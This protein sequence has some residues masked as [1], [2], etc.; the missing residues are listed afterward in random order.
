M[1][2]NQVIEHLQAVRQKHGGDITVMLGQAHPDNNKLWSGV[3]V[4]PETIRESVSEISC[5][6]VPGHEYKSGWVWFQ[7]PDGGIKHRRQPERK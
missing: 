5:T 4:K 7:I 3:E 2:L 1:T 6:S